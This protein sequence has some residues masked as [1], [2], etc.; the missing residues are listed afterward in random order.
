MSRQ[1]LPP[2]IRKVDVLDRRIGKHVVRYQLTVDAGQNPATGKRQQVRRRYVTER[3]ARRALSEITDQAARKEFVPRQAI[4]VDRVCADYIAGR[5]KLRA[6]SLSKL[7]YDLGP[8]RQR[9]GELPLQR[10]TKAHI[11]ALV[12]DLLAG[13]TKTAKGRTRGRWSAV[14]VNKMVATVGQVL[15]DA[16]RQGLV[17][18]NVAEIVDR[19][20]E[21][22][23]SVDTYT[24]DEVRTLL[25]AIADD[26][27]AH[28]WEL[29]LSGL[30]RGEIAGLRW[31]DV[32]LDGKTL[33]IT[34]NRVSAGGTTVENDPKSAT[35][36]RTLPLPDRLMTAL[37]SAK[38]RQAAER[39]ALGVDYS[40]GAYVVSNEVGD[41]YSPAVLS[42]YWRDAVKAAGIRHI[43]LHAARHT[44]ATLMHLSGV[45]VA[46]IA[47]WIGH[48]DASLTMKLY[49]HS[50]AEALKAAGASLDRVVTLL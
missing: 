48:K 9:H 1:Q 42:R 17:S 12:V 23:K 21:P 28:T 24:E 20:P 10:L 25:A 33:T 3:E 15:A 7:D 38:A 13:G 46:V 49:T 2:Q 44:C 18:R 41:P 5:H 43:K 29:A 32:D 35:S 40:S 31:V 34:N 8:L 30:R 37:R 6:S 14:A 4:T 16:Q 36:R 11:D 39:L 26:R 47:A 45:P 50:Q 19:V 22:Y 27:L